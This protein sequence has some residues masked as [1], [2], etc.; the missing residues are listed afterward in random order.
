MDCIDR[1]DKNYYFE[2]GLMEIRRS[3][4]AGR[5]DDF[6][7]IVIGRG[8]VTVVPSCGSRDKSLFEFVQLRTLLYGRDK[9]LN[10]IYVTVYTRI[11]T[12][13][14]ISACMWNKKG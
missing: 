1:S 10:T 8:A 3:M 2:K 13:V 12:S 5:G 4:G 9:N 11:R 7:V 14:N 6:T